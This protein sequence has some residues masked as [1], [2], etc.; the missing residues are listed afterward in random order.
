MEADRPLLPGF[1]ALPRVRAAPPHPDL[2]A[3][4]ADLPEG[5]RMGPSS[6]N[7]P[8]WGDRV[9]LGRPDA[10]T[11]SRE[12]LPAVA[13]F[14]LFR[15]VGVDRSF[16]APVDAATQAAWAAAAPG[17]RF[18][19]KAPAVLTRPLL[20]GSAA[21]NPRFCDPAWTLA[22]VLRPAQA[23]GPSLGAIL[24]QFA[25]AAT[26]EAGG[27]RAF[28]GQLAAWRQALPDAAPLFVELRDPLLV[29][30]HTGR[31]LRELG[32]G[33]CLN[34]CEGM[35]PLPVQAAALSPP[36]Q[37][38]LLRWLTRPGMGYRQAQR[39]FSPFDHLRGADPDTRAVLARLVVDRLRAG[40][41]AW[42]TVANRAEGCIP[43]SVVGLGERIRRLLSR[44]S[45][46]A[47]V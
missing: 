7:Y 30:V 8:G 42:L 46:R 5:L 13:A 20:E 41:T 9:W 36:D 26:R 6:W 21:P 37:P 3:L 2:V 27:A 18:I 28:F 39:A 44:S 4:A 32:L 34:I 19:L 14:P 17:L 29:N 33:V 11:L 12:G 35:P 16:H 1:A 47:S 22:Q 31:I 25:A 24:L 38:L 45:R 40:Q 43:L 10:A 23:L 15:A